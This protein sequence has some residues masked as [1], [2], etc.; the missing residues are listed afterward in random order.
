MDPGTIARLARASAYLM[1]GSGLLLAGA[2]GFARGGFA[3]CGFLLAAVM[4]AT[5]LHGMGWFLLYMAPYGE[6]G[7]STFHVVPASILGFLGGLVATAATARPGWD[8]I[9]LAF[10]YVPFIF[11]PVAVVHAIAFLRI[12]DE[13]VGRSASILVRLGASILIACAALG[14]EGQVVQTLVPEFVAESYLTP[15]L[16]RE[17]SLW[18]FFPYPSALTVFGY[19][20]AWWGWASCAPRERTRPDVGPPRHTVG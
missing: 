8:G 10:P 18:T 11:G 17:I 3:G 16:A 13:G 5:V 4:F 1:G 9:L 12:A 15:G 6:A 14:L 19:A 2:I 7:G 20:L